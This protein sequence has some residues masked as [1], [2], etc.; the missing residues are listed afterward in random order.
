MIQFANELEVIYIQRI[1]EDNFKTSI[2]D[3]PF[4]HYLKYE[5][6]GIKGILSYSLIYDR[7]EINYLWVDILCRKNGIGKLLLS[8]LE[9]IIKR[10]QIENISL[11]VSCKNEVAIALYQKFGFKIVARRKNYYHGDDAFLMIREV[12]E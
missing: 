9:K 6:N 4:V 11:E 3:D 12:K 10:N 2:T 1:L 5:D 8:Y 7:I